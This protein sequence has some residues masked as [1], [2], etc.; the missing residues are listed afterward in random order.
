MDKIQQTTLI[1]IAS[2]STADTDFQGNHTLVL[3]LAV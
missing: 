1:L 2:L 3:S